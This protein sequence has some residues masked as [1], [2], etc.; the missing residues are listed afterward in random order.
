MKIINTCRKL[1]YV[2]T[3][4]LTHANSQHLST[5]Y[6]PYL[7]GLRLYFNIHVT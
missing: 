6:V 2:N 4:V 5:D 7:F 3:H 1:I